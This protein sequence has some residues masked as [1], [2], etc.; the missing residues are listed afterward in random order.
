VQLLITNSRP[1]DT[2]PPN[3][4]LKIAYEGPIPNVGDTIDW[5]G[6]VGPSKV[7]HRYF[8]IRQGRAVVILY[9]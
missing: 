5:A 8:Q 4:L 1:A 2:S 6:S 7:L 9:V 3:E